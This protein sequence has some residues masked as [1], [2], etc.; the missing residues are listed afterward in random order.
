MKY[1]VEYTN[2]AVKQFKKMDRQIAALILSYI[3]K[4]LV[5]CE[6]PRMHGKALQWQSK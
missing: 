1:R 4:N 2:A 5:D 3:E 6:N